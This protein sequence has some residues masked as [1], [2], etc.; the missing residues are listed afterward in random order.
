MSVMFDID[1]ILVT[2]ETAVNQDMH[3]ME[4]TVTDPVKNVRIDRKTV[5]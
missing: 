5:F 3:W 4:E 1:V 2:N